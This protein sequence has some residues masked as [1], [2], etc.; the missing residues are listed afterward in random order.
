MGSGGTELRLSGL[1]ESPCICWAACKTRVAGAWGNFG[2]IVWRV[3]RLFSIAQIP[4]FYFNL[5][6][7]KSQ[8]KTQ[9]QNKHTQQQ[10]PFYSWFSKNQPGMFPGA[11]Q[12]LK[13]STFSHFLQITTVLACLGT[14]PPSSSV[15][16]LVVQP[17]ILQSHPWTPCDTS[18]DCFW[19]RLPSLPFLTALAI[20]GI[21]VIT[22]VQI[23][24][25]EHSFHSFE[26][27]GMGEENWQLCFTLLMCCFILL[28]ME[29]PFTFQQRACPHFS[30]SANA[31]SLFL[32]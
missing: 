8:N 2:R 22:G 16:S 3:V 19:T 1:R 9:M 7:Q 11:L 6:P 20:V 28:S 5:S 10:K 29:V 17:Y 4:F 26:Q 31:W 15:S 14:I 23:H 32:S 30:S 21:S 12:T 13:V 24:P 18:F 27:T 25:G